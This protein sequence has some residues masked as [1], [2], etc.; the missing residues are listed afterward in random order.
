MPID[1]LRANGQY[2][3]PLS[4]SVRVEPVETRART[5]RKSDSQ[6]TLAAAYATN[7][8][9]TS[10]A[11]APGT[12]TWQQ[13][14][15]YLTWIGGGTL[16]LSGANTYGGT[17]T[18]DAGTLAIICVMIPL[19]VGRPALCGVLVAGG[20]GEAVVAL[21]QGERAQLLEGFNA[22]AAEYPR[23]ALIHELFEAQAA[24]QPE[25][26][27][28]V[29][30]DQSAANG[31]WSVGPTAAAARLVAHA[32]AGSKPVSNSTPPLPARCCERPPRPWGCR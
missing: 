29:Y 26:V 31:G 25:A 15:D 28:V 22:T 1:R 23:E 4:K 18:I 13:A 12:D 17:T 7:V 30:E 6:Y 24:Q 11:M 10:R 2:I 8:F 5:Y 20:V 27:A 16:L 19:M 21:T 14:S 9:I 32:G 3:S